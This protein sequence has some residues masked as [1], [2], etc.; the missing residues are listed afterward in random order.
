MHSCHSCYKGANLNKGKI[1]IEKSD[2]V[3]RKGNILKEIRS[4]AKEITVD[5]K[6]LITQP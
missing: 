2:T 3:K 1:K 6:N 5:G 4:Y